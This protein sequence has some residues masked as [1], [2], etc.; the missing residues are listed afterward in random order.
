LD[1]FSC[2]DLRRISFSSIDPCLV[3]GFVIS[4]LE[5][6]DQWAQDITKITTADGDELFSIES[7]SGII[8]RSTAVEVDSD[9]VDIDFEPI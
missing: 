9:I 7:P 1:T 2:T 6:L 5:T 4:D 8:E 3:A